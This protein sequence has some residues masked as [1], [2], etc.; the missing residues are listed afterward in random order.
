MGK[1][2]DL[3]DATLAIG[4]VA[5]RAGLQTSAIRYYERVG[6]L[7]APERISGRRR[8]GPEVLQLLAAIEAS[9][10]AGFSLEEIKRLFHGFDRAT[11]PS[12]RWRELATTKLEELDGVAERLEGM[13]SLLQRGLECGCLSLEDCKLVSERTNS[14]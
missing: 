6:L 10:A 7:P 13:R 9:K 3:T 5:E 12:A 8:Y 2:A 14:S 1:E 4:E 11:P